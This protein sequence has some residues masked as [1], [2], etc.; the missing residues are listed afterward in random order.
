[1]LLADLGADVVKVEG[2]NGDDTRGWVPPVADGVSTYFLGVNRG[3]RSVALDLRDE[4]DAG[5]ARELARRADVVIENFKPGG[6]AKYGLDHP[7]V[8]ADNPKVIYASITGFGS[9]DGKHVP[10]YDLMV[11]A[12]SGLMSLTGDPDGPPYR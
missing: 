6:L 5:L 1:M 8:S 11:Q 7:S 3:K 12:I 2:P 4:T 10:G 9:G